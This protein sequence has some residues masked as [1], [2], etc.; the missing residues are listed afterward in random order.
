MQYLLRHPSV[1]DILKVLLSSKWL[2]SNRYYQK[3]MLNKARRYASK[4]SRVKTGVCIETTLN[5]NSRCIMCAHSVKE[6]HG[7]MKK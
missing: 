5:C 2:N 7:T 4:Y 3:Y 1:M 6:M